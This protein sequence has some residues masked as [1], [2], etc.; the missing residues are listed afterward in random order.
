MG[1]EGV[2]SPGCCSAPRAPRPTSAGT[3]HPRGHCP[4]REP[5][6][7]PTPSPIRRSKRP[8]SPSQQR[9]APA[10]SASPQPCL[11]FPRPQPGMPCGRR[12]VGR[13]GP[14]PSGRW[15]VRRSALSQQ[16]GWRCV[17]PAGSLR[18][19]AEL[20][21]P[22]WAS[23][24]GLTEV[25]GNCDRVSQ[26]AGS[27]AGWGGGRGRGPARPPPGLGADQV[28][29]PQAR[30]GEDPPGRPS[31]WQRRAGSRGGGRRRKEGR[32]ERPGPHGCLN[33]AEAQSRVS[34]RPSQGTEGGPGG[35]DLE[36]QRPQVR[37]G[38]R[39]AAPAPPVRHPPHG[40]G[41][42]TPGAPPHCCRPP[43]SVASGRVL[44][45]RGAS[46]GSPPHPHGVSPGCPSPRKEQTLSLHPGRTP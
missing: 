6:S 4:G 43:S 19:E 46:L 27:A 33:R 21:L 41:R 10:S 2:G 35:K 9:S 11:D 32:R 24:S 44:P 28:C 23:D 37:E 7:A 30:W 22:L 3:T 34:A 26:K 5:D 25:R 39:P 14:E 29:A 12:D 16:P 8:R 17:P 1:G 13:G 40:G 18:S 42:G 31:P 38:P 36:N 45:P 15:G 20:G